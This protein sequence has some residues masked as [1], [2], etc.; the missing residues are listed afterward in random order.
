MRLLT[1]AVVALASLPCLADAV[2]HAKEP[3]RVAFLNGSL[4]LAP[5]GDVEVTARVLKAPFGARREDGREQFA[6]SVGVSLGDV[7]QVRDARQRVHR[8]RVSVL[9]AGF[10]RVEVLADE[11]SPPAPPQRRFRCAV[12][13]AN[14]QPSSSSFGELVLSDDGTYQLGRT[15]GAWRREDDGVR[16]EG[17]LAHW[18]PT[19]AGDDGARLGFTFQRG[20]IE[21]TL[22]FERVADGP[23]AAR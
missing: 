20:P 3:A 17:P 6:S 23:L 5:D 8:V 18:R 4:S 14:G 19:A 12:V 10:V 21:W 2:L 9:S 15:Q 22:Q 7:Y 11:A 13:T 16:L 1:A